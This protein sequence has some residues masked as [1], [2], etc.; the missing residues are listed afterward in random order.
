VTVPVGDGGRVTLYSSSGGQLLADVTGY[1]APSGA[2]SAGRFQALSPSRL[3]DTRS[4]ARPA[5]GAT[6]PLDVTG[7]GGVPAEG[8]SAVVLSVTATRAASSG[9]VQVVPTGGSTAIGS[10]SSLNVA[11][12]QTVANLVVVPVGRDGT[13]SL[14]TSG[15]T[16]LLADVAGWVTDPSAPSASSGLFVA[17]EPTR[18]LDT[19]LATAP[20]D[21]TQVRLRPLALLG[22]RGTASA[23][24]LNV[25]ATQATGPGFVQVF[26]TG[27]ATPRHLVQP[28]PRAGRPDGRRRCG[29]RPRRRRGGL[30]ARG[31]LD[32]PARRRRRLLHVTIRR[33]ARPERRLGLASAGPRADAECTPLTRKDA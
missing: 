24:V 3:L 30:P 11:E 15:G 28:Q 21:G 4:G 18:L 6:I 8:A 16:H 14:H 25:T 26:P 22:T 23:V 17:V 12:G 31:P 32:A 27:R 20:P 1:Y 2:T 13:V 10:S 33:S 9:F 7:R 5:A 29:Q 19:R